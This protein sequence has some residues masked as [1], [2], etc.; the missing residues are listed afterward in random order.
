MRRAVLTVLALAALAA[1]AAVV[2][3]T[4][5]S[6]AGAA[7]HLDAPG[8]TPPGGDVRVDITD[9]Y[10]FRAG[11]G[12]SVLVL[13]VNGFTKPGKRATFAS[14][15]PS[16]RETKRVEYRLNVDDDGDA[17]P[18][19]VFGITFGRPNGSGIQP[20][21]VTRNGSE[22]VSGQTSANGQIRV[23]RGGGARVFAGLRDDPF[24]FDLP[25]FLNI[26]S[27][28]RGESFLGCTAPRK[29]A[30]AKTNV[31][32]IVLELPNRLLVG[33][34]SQ[35]GVWA[36]TIRGG[37]QIDRMGRPAIA[38][39]F[40]P[41]NPFEVKGSEPSQK[42]RF[43]ETTPANDRARFRG[44]VVDTL[45]TLFSLNDSAG[46][47]KA[48]DGRKINGLADV[49]LPDVLT[50][51]TAS[52]KGFLNGRRLADDVIDAELDLITEG[53]AKT[54]CVSRNDKRFRNAFPYLAAPHA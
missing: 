41:N 1:T 15:V 50:F 6:Q 28:K 52:S 51:D 21:T 16:V 29:D 2:A 5:P 8:V 4:V 19:T 48:D 49:L 7:D 46:D 34:K 26:L 38:T 24:F 9:I 11:N 39:V 32:S 54:D 53:A 36:T 13:N 3:R 47:D 23:N 17:R 20:L 30:F 14:S 25:G 44:E 18:D 10:A 43:N 42:K 22:L 35:I 31:S 40:I 45:R 12:R 33:Q 37:K 27:D